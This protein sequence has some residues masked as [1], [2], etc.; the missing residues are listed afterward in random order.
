MFALGESH[1]G[2]TIELYF[3]ERAWSNSSVLSSFFHSNS[4]SLS[5]WRFIPALRSDQNDQQIEDII[6]KKEKQDK[7]MKMLTFLRGE[8]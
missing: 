4:E 2:S 8:I 7:D 6:R 1:P 5:Q 3:S